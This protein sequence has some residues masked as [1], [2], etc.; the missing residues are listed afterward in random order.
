MEQIYSE[1]IKLMPQVGMSVNATSSNPTFGNAVKPTTP[2]PYLKPAPAPATTPSSSAISDLKA[3]LQQQKQQLQIKQQLAQQQQQIQQLQ[4]QQAWEIQQLQQQHV[5][6]F[7]FILYLCFN[8]LF[9]LLFILYFRLLTFFFYRRT[10]K[11]PAY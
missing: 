7:I 2:A 5:Q 3:K 10:L 11:T 4:Q 9:P 1:T 6:V 8:S